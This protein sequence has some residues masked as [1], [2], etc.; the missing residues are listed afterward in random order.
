MKS[1]FKIIAIIL[2][3]INLVGCNFDDETTSEKYLHTFYEGDGIFAELP[4]TVLGWDFHGG[5]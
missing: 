4:G 2:F 5:D 3:A 1:T